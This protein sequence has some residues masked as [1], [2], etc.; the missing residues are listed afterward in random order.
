MTLKL[1]FRYIHIHTYVLIRSYNIENITN[2]TVRLIIF[3]VTKRNF[4]SNNE[5]YH[6]V[7]AV[8]FY[9]GQI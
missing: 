5:S 6:K 4:R 3:L 9:T 8:E 1:C 2:N 7:S